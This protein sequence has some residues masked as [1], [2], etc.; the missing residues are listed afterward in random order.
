MASNPIDAI[1][2]AV[3][4]L[5]GQK[6]LAEAIGA[7]QSNIS[8]AANGERKIPVRQ[9]LKIEEVTGGQVTKEE[10]RPDIF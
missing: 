8:S 2:R 10:L 5:G 4:I 7:Y 6:E 3:E 1:L 9:A